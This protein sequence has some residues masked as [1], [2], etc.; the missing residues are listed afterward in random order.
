MDDKNNTEKSGR[1]IHDYLTSLDEAKLIIPV[2]ISLTL[3]GVSHYS[4][5]L[6]HTLAEFIAVTIGMLM[7]AVAWNVYKYSRNNFLMFLASG[8]F[9]VS[10]IDLF[11]LL[12]YKGMNI[13]PIMNSTPSIELWLSARYMEAMTLLIGPYF[14][15]RKINRSTTFLGYMLITLILATMV[16]NDIFP[17]VFDEDIGLTPFKVYSEY[18]IILILASAMLHIIRQRTHI[19]RLVFNFMVF[20]II[21]TMLAELAFTF[22]ISAYG[23]SNLVGHIFKVFS[24]WFLFR[25]IVHTTLSQ[26]YQLLSAEVKVRRKAELSLTSSNRALRVLDA[27]NKTIVNAGN[28]QELLEQVCKLIA[29]TGGYCLAWIGYKYDNE[30]KSLLCM[31]S[32]G[33]KVDFIRHPHLTWGELEEGGFPPGKAIREG[34]GVV[35]QNIHTDINCV[36]CRDDAKKY[37][38]NSVI[39]LPLLINAQVLG[40]LAI[41]ARER[42]AFTFEEINLLSDLANELSYA[43]EALRMRSKHSQV[44]KDLSE[45]EQK[46]RNLSEQ[47]LVGVYIV[48]D[49]KFKYINPRL[50]ELFGYNS[51]NEVI[52]KIPL[53]DIVYPDDWGLVKENLR[54]RYDGE[55][56]ASHYEF[57]YVTRDGRI[58]DAEVF[59]SASVYKNNPAVLGTFLDITE[60]KHADENIRKSKDRLRTIIDAEPECVKTIDANGNLLDINPAGLA[61]LEVD[62]LDEVVGK[63]LLHYVDEPYREEFRKLLQ[64]I[65]KGQSRMLEF[66][67]TG[68][69]GGHHFMETHAVPIIE[70]GVVS[71]L[72]AVTRDIS[73]HKHAEKV[74]RENA[75]E[76]QRLLTQTVQSV[77]LTVEKRDPYTSGHQTRVAKLSV[78]IAQEMGLN[79]ERI[80]GI[81]LG[82]TIHDIGKIYIPAEILNR[83]G[84]LTAS[85]YG[86][87]QSHPQVGYD[88]M[89]DVEFPWPVNEIIYQHH[90]RID[91]TGYPQGLKDNEIALEARIVAVADVVEAITSH[92][93]YRPALGL[94][95]G[96]NEIKRGRG[97]AYDSVVV[98]ACVKLYEAGKIDFLKL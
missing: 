66:E 38:F 95:I 37:G 73:Q 71:T 15:L 2:L 80:I 36:P 21:L 91:G 79:E 88:I 35:I 70:D 13:F 41:Y 52:D 76:K 51:V 82:A 27:T 44:S 16:I 46:F 65:F 57:R 64:D 17:H 3:I 68:S 39:A 97:S 58:R 7:F 72:L 77:A 34:Q 9:W 24:F 11:H 96:I 63:P 94:E 86:L 28:E 29:V 92:R 20:S 5:L 19:S 45:T 85:E 98:D 31:A 56:Q 87:I 49:N 25:A 75:T 53:K 30:G 1:L 78:L 33:I 83:P 22:Y 69:K 84:K 23:L 61:M 62:S 12:T 55:I 67:I 18:A 4:Y 89:K 50:A 93:P 47:S 32:A 10:I 54:K 43:I 48:Q 6:F 59:G 40:V 42:N 14:I 74:L 90:E 60:R 81:Q 8:Y 26:P